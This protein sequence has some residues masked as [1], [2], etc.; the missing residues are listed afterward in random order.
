M[1]IVEAVKDRPD[2]FAQTPGTLATITFDEVS[3]K[4]VNP[5]FIPIAYGFDGNPNAPTVSFHG[6]FQG[7]SMDSSKLIVSGNPQGPHLSLDPRS[8]NTTVMTADNNPSF[9]LLP[10]ALGDVEGPA[11][12]LLS[13]PVAAIVVSWLWGLGLNHQP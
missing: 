10:T 13:R 2:A 4:T 7:Q 8:P 11:A 1:P 12:L 6:Y 3:E 5:T 9:S